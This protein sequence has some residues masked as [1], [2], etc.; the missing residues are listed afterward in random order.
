M[1]KLMIGASLALALAATP[2]F[3]ATYH[4]RLSAQ[5]NDAYAASENGVT[6][7]GPALYATDGQYLGWDPDPAIRHDLIRQGDESEN[8]N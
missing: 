1:K 7:N 4:S 6:A 8:G 2:A 5:S 3:A